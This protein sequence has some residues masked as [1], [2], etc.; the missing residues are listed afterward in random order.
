MVSNE[1]S[2]SAVTAPTLMVPRTSILKD[3][4]FEVAIQFG[5][6]VL[7]LSLMLQS[8]SPLLSSSLE[9]VASIE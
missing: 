6:P 1:I 9:D 3:Q 7:P 5:V 4:S 8:E 2:G